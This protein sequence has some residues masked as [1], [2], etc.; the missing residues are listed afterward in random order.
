[1]RTVKALFR[2]HLTSRQ[3][4]LDDRNEF[5]PLRCCVGVRE[6]SAGIE[7]NVGSSDDRDWGHLVRILENL[8]G[9]R[10]SR[11]WI[12]F[13]QR[14]EKYGEVAAVFGLKPRSVLKEEN[15]RICVTC[16]HPYCAAKITYKGWIDMRSR[17]T[18]QVKR[19]IPLAALLGLK[20]FVEFDL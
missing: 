4:S 9:A 17:S 20:R 3:S 18:Q 6:R 8:P 12:N 13:L 15:S 16:I 1:M 19:L 11:I 7:H 10:Q 5:S 2:S 14:V